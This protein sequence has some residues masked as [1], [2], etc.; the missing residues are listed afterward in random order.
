[1]RSSPS[2][3]PG[4]SFA[5]E[6]SSHEGAAPAS[7]SIDEAGTQG[8]SPGRDVDSVVDAGAEGGV[9]GGVIIAPEML[10]RG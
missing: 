3:A 5:D 8:V 4:A 6:R 2:R 7:A 1:M 9:D 10:D